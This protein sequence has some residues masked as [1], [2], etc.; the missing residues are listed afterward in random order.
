MSKEDKAKFLALEG[1]GSS[2]IEDSGI[3]LL[4][5]GINE[6]SAARVIK[7]IL[8]MNIKKVAGKLPNV[9]ELMLMVN[10]PG[11]S[12]P[13]AFALID[14]MRGSKL[15]VNTIGL[16]L[17][18]SCGLLIFMAGENRVLTP[19]TSI[20]S[21]QWSWAAWG[22]EHELFATVK[23]FDLTKERILAHYK[24]YSKL[25]IKQ[26]NKV[27][28]PAHDVWL[29]AEDALKHGLCDEIKTV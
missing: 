2:D 9:K 1:N 25:N 24:K 7:W 17:I 16:G 19:N 5:E 20:L 10:S 3:Y 15:K 13:D 18:A 29:S 27:L 26:I 28:L 4:M 8:E 14:I 12:V 11:G 6:D 23:E 21:H 22:K